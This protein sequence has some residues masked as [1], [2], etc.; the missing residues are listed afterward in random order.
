[1]S[2]A[3]PSPV[4]SSTHRTA[5]ALV[6][7][8]KEAIAEGALALIL[9]A[10]DGGRLP[11]WSPGAH[12]D[13]HLGEGRIRQYSLCGD[14][15]DPTTYRI[16]VKLDPAGGGGSRYIH[17]Q[18]QVGDVIPFGGPRNTFR[19][20]PAASY[21]F[22]GA[23]IGITPMLPMI[24]QAV[25]LGL[26]W[27]CVALAR[28]RAT[29]PFL[30][31]LFSFGENVEFLETSVT[32]RCDLR[33]TIGALDGTTGVYACGPE[34]FLSSL[35]QLEPEL[36]LLA[37]G[38]RVEHFTA[39]SDAGPS[40]GTSSF[41]LELARS[42]R[43]LQVAPDQSILDVL[44]AEGRTVLASCEKGLCGTCDTDVVA[45]APDHRDSV[46]APHEREAGDCMMVCVS[47]SLTPR[48]TIDL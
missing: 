5:T 17:E 25:R 24:N 31:E 26:P 19:M 1:M 10:P 38:L 39:G 15:W 13:L 2:T 18:L 48:L 46:L 11:D 40:G 37:G 41:E 47:R 3:L 42:G 4:V 44:R 16:G 28:T 30:D 34:R 6:V 22:L 33:E 21:L 32:G 8:A 43:V 36:N 7:V 35:Q 20:H 12:I 29:M 45:G 27:R 23:G 14:R 9:G